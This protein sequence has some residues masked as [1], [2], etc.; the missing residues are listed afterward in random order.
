MIA[1]SENL[2]ISIS[3]KSIELIGFDEVSPQS[4]MECLSL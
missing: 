1:K 4:H 2:I 3:L